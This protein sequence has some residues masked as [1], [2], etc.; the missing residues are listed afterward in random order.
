MKVGD[1]DWEFNTTCLGTDDE[2]FY[3]EQVE[4]DSGTT[5]T[6]YE[7]ESQP[8]SDTKIIMPAIFF[9]MLCVLLGIM[10]YKSV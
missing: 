7:W 3:F 6:C 2:G 8:F 5:L 10:I 9:V 4:D 1:S